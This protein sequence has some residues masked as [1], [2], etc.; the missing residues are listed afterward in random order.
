[1]KHIAEHGHGA[2]FYLANHEG[3]PWMLILSL[4]L[5]MMHAITAMR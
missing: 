4:D 3:R 1:M 5:L 2:L